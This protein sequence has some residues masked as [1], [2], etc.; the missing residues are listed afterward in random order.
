MPGWPPDTAHA[1]LLKAPDATHIFEG[2]DLAGSMRE[3]TP[4]RVVL[5]HD[6]VEAGITV[7]SF[8][9]GDLLCPAGKTPLYLGQPVALLIWND[10]ARFAV[11]KHDAP[12]RARRLSFRRRNRPGSGGA[13]RGRALRARCRPVAG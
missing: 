6:L 1:M 5:A 13:L 9:A 10:F 4:D 12:V 3:L 11:A 7:P 2:I 8:Y